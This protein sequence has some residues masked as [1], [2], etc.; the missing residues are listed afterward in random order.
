[1]GLALAV[2]AMPDNA[3]H[4]SYWQIMLPGGLLG[5]IVGIATRKSGRQSFDNLPAASPRIVAA[6][7]QEGGEMPRVVHFEIQAENTERAAR[8]Y[9]RTFD[10]K[11]HRWEGP[12]EYWLISTDPSSDRGIDGGLLPRRGNI[13]GIMQADSSAA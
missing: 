5:I 13:F 3:G 7:V 8:F 10:W 6:V 1:M 12:Q 2:A 4:H 11:F 9:E